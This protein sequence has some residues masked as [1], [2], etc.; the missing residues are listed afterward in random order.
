MR[1]HLG[2]PVGCAAEWDEDGTPHTYLAGAD[3]FHPASCPVILDPE[4]TRLAA[5]RP[6]SAGS[7]TGAIRFSAAVGTT[8]LPHPLRVHSD[9]LDWPEASLRN[10]FALAF[11]RR[12]GRLALG[13]AG[14]FWGT[15]RREVW[16]SSASVLTGVSLAT[17]IDWLQVEATGELGARLFS[18]MPTW[19]DMIA[20]PRERFVVP[21]AGLRG[22]IGWTATRWAGL[23]LTLF[24]E[25]DL[26]R[27]QR[28]RYSF[29][30]PGSDH[31][32]PGC[33]DIDATW[34]IGGTS[35]GASLEL[36]FLI[37]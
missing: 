19:H 24:V 11:R 22:A 15:N 28:G 14:S 3:G 20:L 1:Y 30:D 17:G 26:P 33:T 31:I 10:N 27:E 4:A 8:Y 37:H 34:D 25:Q 9:Q 12:V 13:V 29:C 36:R 16:S 35:L 32:P 18:V 6:A 2:E 5:S 21:Y 23:Y 7:E